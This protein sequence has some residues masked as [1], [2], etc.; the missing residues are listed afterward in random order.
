MVTVLVGDHFR[1]A[2]G[3]VAMYRK[4]MSGQVVIGRVDFLVLHGNSQY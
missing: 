4:S 1:D 2:A 3:H